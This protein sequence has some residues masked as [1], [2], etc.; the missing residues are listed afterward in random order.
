M[1]R[2]FSIASWSAGTFL[3]VVAIACVHPRPGFA[4]DDVAAGQAL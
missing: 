3:T 2:A 1:R 4:A